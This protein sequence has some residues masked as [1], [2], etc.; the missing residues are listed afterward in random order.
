MEARMSDP[1]PPFGRIPQAVKAR[2][3]SRSKLYEIAA[4]HEGV[5]QKLDSMTIVNFSR[6]DNVLKNLPAAEL[7]GT[8]L[9]MKGKRP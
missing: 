7:P 5:F 1:S 2:G 9:K 8:A 6:L 3:I 4:Q